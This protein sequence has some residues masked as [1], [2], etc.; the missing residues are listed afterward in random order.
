MHL[1]VSIN[2]CLDPD[3]GNKQTVLFPAFLSK[4]K[5]FSSQIIDFKQTKRE[6]ISQ[7]LQDIRMRAFQEIES[8]CDFENGA[9]KVNSSFQAERIYIFKNYAAEI[10]F[11]RQ[12]FRRFVL[13]LPYC[14]FH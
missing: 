5:F 7:R 11:A 9:E 4:K 10:T 2:S 1:I 12:F 13:V 8:I 3:A 14:M 6:K